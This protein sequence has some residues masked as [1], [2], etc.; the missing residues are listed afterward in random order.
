MNLLP[1]RFFYLKNNEPSSFYATP[2]S[3][4]YGESNVSNLD[5]IFQ[6][7]D[8]DPRDKQKWKQDVFEAIRLHDVTEREKR[9]EMDKKAQ[10]SH[11]VQLDDIVYLKKQSRHPKLEV[12]YLV[13]TF[14]ELLL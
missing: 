14:T 5:D 1:R 11:P 7:P 4:A 10:E 3:M 8:L 12:T 6:Y 13:R 2:I 9:E